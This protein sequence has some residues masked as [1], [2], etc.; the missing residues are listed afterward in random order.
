MS[1]SF[2]FYILWGGG[3]INHRQPEFQGGYETK[4]N[5]GASINTHQFFK[6]KIQIPVSCTR[7]FALQ[8]V[9][10]ESGRRTEA[11]WE[12]ARIEGN[13]VTNSV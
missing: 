10:G 8:G 2:S 7:L 3:E 13:Q 5:L 9:W 1:F 6:W 11:I 12:K 4:S